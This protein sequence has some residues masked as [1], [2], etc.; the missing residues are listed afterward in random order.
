MQT[1][2]RIIITTSVLI[3]SASVW[4]QTS[5]TA[6]RPTYYF[7]TPM[8]KVN[9]PNHRVLGFHEISFGLPAHLQIQA[10]LMD[11]IGRMN[12]GAKYGLNENLAIG[13]GL[14]H[15][16]IHYTGIVL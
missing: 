8:A 4:A 15:S 10:S 1:V 2:T 12:I 11:N 3:F 14:A 9:P 5:I 7:Y 16:I 6:S 13:A